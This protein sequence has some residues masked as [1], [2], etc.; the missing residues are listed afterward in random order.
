MT[1]PAGTGEGHSMDRSP[2]VATWR[3]PWA[4]VEEGIPKTSMCAVVMIVIAV[5]AGLINYVPY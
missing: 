5:L 2:K 3:S 1:A 4:V